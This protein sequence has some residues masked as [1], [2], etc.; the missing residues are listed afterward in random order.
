MVLRI[1]ILRK[2]RLSD[3]PP[4]TGNRRDGLRR[5]NRTFWI[6][7]TSGKNLIRGGFGALA[8]PGLGARL[9][10]A[11]NNKVERT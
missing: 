7:L 11:A 9:K 1:A 2:E 8:R 3:G 10:D 4:K 6:L 5:R